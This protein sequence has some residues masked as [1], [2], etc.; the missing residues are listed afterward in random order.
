V[1]VLGGIPFVQVSKGSVL[2]IAYVAALTVVLVAVCW[3]KGESPRR[4]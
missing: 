3:L 4:H 2:Y 1:L